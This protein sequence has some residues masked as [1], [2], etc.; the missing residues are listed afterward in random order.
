M[1]KKL[2]VEY[3]HF[4]GSMDTM[5]FRMM[6][7]L[8]PQSLLKK[9]MMKM[10]APKTRPLDDYE[11]RQ[12]DS[13]EIVE[14]E[15]NKIWLVRHTCG[16]DNPKDLKAM[17]LDPTQQNYDKCLEAAKLMGDDSVKQLD[18]D[19]V[20][21]KEYLAIDPK[22]GKKGEYNKACAGMYSIMVVVK[23]KSGD[24]LLYNPVPIHDGTKLD[25]WMKSMGDVKYAVIGSC[26]H[27]LFLPDT[28]KR[29][30]DAIYIG[31]KISEEKLKA[32]NALKK[33]KL[34]YDALV[35]SDITTVNEI[36]EAGGVTLKFTKGDMLTQSIFLVAYE[37]GVEV[38]LLYGLH[39]TC[40]CDY[41]K[42]E[43]IFKGCDNDPRHFIGRL[44]QWR[45]VNKPNSPYGY[46]PP[47]RFAAMDPKSG[48]SK[49]NWPRP[50]NDGSSC[51]E[52]ANSLRE[53]LKMDYK[54]VVSIHWGL[55]SAEDFRLSINEDWKWLDESSL[56]PE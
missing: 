27:T 28:L 19:W 22:E 47:Y 56:L 12:V 11:A 34:D 8:M 21:L 10:S 50:A 30:P 43:G 39:D 2:H 17:G 4:A 1:A 41:S 6:A 48:L 49:M 55:L 33:P 40:A 37:T 23:L 3:Q 31:T 38:D 24:L 9:M 18:K 16:G 5:G 44:F 35:E 53:I 36:L 26:Y 51:K 25:E 14:V 29:Y 7:K 32:A 52:M 20:T 46:L 15:E 45:L 54:N 13:D 42:A